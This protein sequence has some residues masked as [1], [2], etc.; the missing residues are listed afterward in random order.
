MNMDTKINFITSSRQLKVRATR[1]S[2]LAWQ[3]LIRLL[4]TSKPTWILILRGWNICVNSKRILV[5]VD[6]LFEVCRFDT[7]DRQKWF[8]LGGFFRYLDGIEP[9]W[10]SFG[11]RYMKYQ[12]WKP[13]NTF[14][15]LFIG[16][17]RFCNFHL[18]SLFSSAKL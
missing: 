13:E 5:L 1:P 10:V 3:I 11:W 16:E 9:F 6:I 2:I 7:F 15:S 12:E 8:D 4:G 17:C 18:L 14:S